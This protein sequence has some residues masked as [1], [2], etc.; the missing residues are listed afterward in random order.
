MQAQTWKNNTQ[1]AA[2][3][4]FTRCTQK[5]LQLEKAISKVICQTYVFMQPKAGWNLDEWDGMLMLLHAL[6]GPEVKLVQIKNVPPRGYLISFFVM[7]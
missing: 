3:L 6:H 1:G 4:I 7:S 5:L 2:F